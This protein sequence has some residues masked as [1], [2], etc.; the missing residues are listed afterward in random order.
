MRTKTQRLML[1]PIFTALIAVGAFLRVPVPVV[2]FTLQFFF[3]ALAG[4][5]LGSSLGAA[6]VAIYVLLGLAGLPIFAEGGGI[7]YVLRPSF[8]YLIGFIAGT[9]VTG[10]MTEKKESPGVLWLVF[11]SFVGL[12]LVYT[13]GIAYMWLIK[14]VYLGSGTGLWPLLVYGLFLAI[15]GD[16]VLCIF[17]GILGK[18]LRIYLCKEGILRH[19]LRKSV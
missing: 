3:T 10:L 5:S 18:R 19:E 14:D 13:M 15:P 16:L 6:S 9:F 8:G 17:S 1:C 12:L 4:I 7:S 2:P 11:S